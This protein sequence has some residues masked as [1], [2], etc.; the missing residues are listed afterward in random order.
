MFNNW[1]EQL[2]A[3]AD[4]WRRHRSSSEESAKR[5]RGKKSAAVS[6]PTASTRTAAESDTGSS[7]ADDDTIEPPPKK[8]TSG[9]TPATV[10]EAE[11]EAANELLPLP[12]TESLDAQGEVDAY[13]NYTL[14]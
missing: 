2:E 1:R 6:P 13:V 7:E 10:A 9:K 14:H 11:A 8:R 4:S 12:S 5:R 3:K